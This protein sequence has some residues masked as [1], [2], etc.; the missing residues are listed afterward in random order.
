MGLTKKYKDII[1]NK[2]VLL[3]V[4]LASIGNILYFAYSKDIR[5]VGVF[6]LVGLL[7][8]FFSKNML[9]IMAVALV[10][11][12][13]IRQSGKEGF[14]KKKISKTV[15]KKLSKTKKKKEEENTDVVDENDENTEGGKW[16]DNKLEDKAENIEDDIADEEKEEVEEV[17]EEE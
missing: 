10:V 8:S 15:K 14:A 5:S 4:L 3:F 9:V 12:N 13:V 17:E 7:T 2:S 16:K 6:F 11:S 1:G